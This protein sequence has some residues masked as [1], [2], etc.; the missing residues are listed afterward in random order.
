MVAIK[1]PLTKLSVVPRPSSEAVSVF[2]RTP[3]V[4]GDALLSQIG[5][6]ARPLST[7]S[8]VRRLGRTQPQWGFHGSPTKLEQARSVGVRPASN[9]CPGSVMAA[10]TYSSPSCLP[11]LHAAS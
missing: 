7:K 3:P 11:S 1:L 4:Y 10:R 8:I 5:W 6:A 9:Y 2:G